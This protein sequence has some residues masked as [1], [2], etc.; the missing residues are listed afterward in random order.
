MFH[1]IVN[2]PLDKTDQIQTKYWCKSNFSNRLLVHNITSAILPAMVQLTTDSSAINSLMMI[3]KFQPMKNKVQTKEQFVSH[4]SKTK[5]SIQTCMTHLLRQILD[6]NFQSAR[7]KSVPPA[8][9][10]LSSQFKYLTQLCHS[11]Q[12]GTK[13]CNMSSQTKTMTKTAKKAT[14]TTVIH[15]SIYQTVS[16]YSLPCVKPSGNEIAAATITSCQ[17]QK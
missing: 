4:V 12:S 15:R 10:L 6:I 7:S 5:N 17:P 13:L 16:A 14:Q 2:N 3:N 9:N 11:N 8:L 1:L